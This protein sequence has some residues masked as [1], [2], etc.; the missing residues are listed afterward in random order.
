MRQAQEIVIGVRCGRHQSQPVKAHI[1]HGAYN[2]ADIRRVLRVIQDDNELIE[3]VHGGGEPI[4]CGAWCESHV[5][6]HLGDTA[7]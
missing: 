2:G 7:P 5:M 3:W 6:S 1:L 4:G